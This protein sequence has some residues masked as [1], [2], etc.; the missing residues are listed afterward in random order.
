MFWDPSNLPGNDNR[1]SSFEHSDHETEREREM[2]DEKVVALI[3]IHLF[4]HLFFNKHSF[5]TK[6]L[7]RNCTDDR[8][9][10]GKYK[11]V[12][13]DGHSTLRVQ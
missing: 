10:I 5:I 4:I 13:T 9:V 2:K 6:F 7:L 1:G 3:N 12:K 11:E 8:S